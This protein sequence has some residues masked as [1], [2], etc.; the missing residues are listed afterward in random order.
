MEERPMSRRLTWDEIQKEY[1]D[2]WVG[3]IDVERDGIDIVSAIVK[4]ADK[5]QGELTMLQIDDDDLYSCYTCPD[6]LAPLGMIGY[7]L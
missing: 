4:Y 7:G 2:Q 3:L 5:T 6:H 1:P